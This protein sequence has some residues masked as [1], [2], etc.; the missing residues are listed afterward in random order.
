[1]HFAFKLQT[2]SWSLPSSSQVYQNACDLGATFH[3]KVT[4]WLQCIHLT[5]DYITSRSQEINVTLEEESKSVTVP[6]DI[7]RARLVMNE[8]ERHVSFARANPS[9]ERTDEDWEEKLNRYGGSAI[10]SISIIKTF[11]CMVVAHFCCRL[12]WHSFKNKHNC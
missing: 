5:S 11:L 8:C 6:Y 3:R 2:G 1:M 4:L 9:D 10:Q 12:Q 7:A